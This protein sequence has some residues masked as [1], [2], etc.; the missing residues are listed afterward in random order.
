MA[1]LRSASLPLLGVGLAALL[2]CDAVLPA[3]PSP[4]S[5][6]DGPLDG[7]TSQQRAAFFAGDREFG[8][9]FATADGLGPIFVAASCG[10]CHVGDGKGHPAFNLSRF[11]RMANGVFDPMRQDGGPQVQNRAILNYLAEVV[12]P[13]ATGVAQFTAP[14]VTGLGFLEAVEDADILALADPDDAD[15]DGISGRVQL[16]GA[17][18][19]IAEVSRLELL[20]DPGE[21]SRHLPIGGR[22]I[23][24]FGKKASA[25]NL[26]HQAVTAYREDMGLTTDLIIEDPVNPQVGNFAG[27]DVPD[28]EIPSNTVSN[29][30]FYLKT[31]R[32]PPRRQAESPG[33]QAGEAQFVQSAC[34]RCHVPALTTGASRIAAL[35]RKVF[36]PYTDLLLHDMGPELD[37][38]YTEGV[39]LTSEWRTPP[40]WGLGLAGNA[41]GGRGFFLHDGRAR[42]LREA[43]ELHGGEAAA[44]RDAFRRLTAA[45]QELVLAFLR[46]L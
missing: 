33:V 25:I 44:S 32:P 20:F 5:I 40:L 23:G 35:N 43:I 16:V 41:Q 7:L 2:A 15:G 46:S 6:L 8:R 42:S 4:D 1:R 28:P 30:V 29:V 37:D 36:H 9:I 13:G 19:L 27:D 45:E 10:S 17:S 38:G 11:G 26:L 21:P 14:S 24:R 18:D 22:Y 31:L 3:A 34:S 39:A 12:P